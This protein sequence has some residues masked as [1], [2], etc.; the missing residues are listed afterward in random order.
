MYA[1]AALLDDRLNFREAVL[2]AILRF[3][4][5]AGPEPGA[6]DGEDDGVE[7]RLELT[8]E[9]AVYENVARRHH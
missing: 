2:S 4:S 3:K 7:N 6:D 9:S 1:I 5:A 8:I